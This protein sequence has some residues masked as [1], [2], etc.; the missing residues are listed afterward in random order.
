M[1]TKFASS[2]S[3]DGKKFFIEVTGI[4]HGSE[5]DFEF[6]DL[7]DMSQQAALEAKK[8]ID[9]E[10]DESTVY[11]WDWCDESA[12]RNVWLK[13]EAEGDPI[14]LP[15]FQ[16]VAD[17]PR[18]KD[19][20]DYLVHAVLP[21]TLLPTYQSSLT[22]KE[23]I[24][25][26]RAGFIYIFYNH[27][28]W[29]EIQISP[30][31]SGDYS[32]KDVNLYQYRTGRDKPFKDEARIATG[33]A[34]KEIW[35]PAKENNKGARIH[36]AFSEVQWSA[37]YLNYLEAN[38]NELV[39]RAVA[40]HQLNVDSNVDVLKASLLPPMRIRAPE[41]ELFLAEP[42]NLNRDLSGEWVT[43]TYQTI[44]E[45]ILSANDDGDKAVQVFKYAQPHRYEYA[46]KQAALIEIINSDPNQAKLWTIGDSTDFLEDAKKR[47]LRAIVLDDPLF[48]LRHH[49]FLTQSAVGYLQQ[50]YIDMSQQKYY[51][52]AE[53]VQKLVVPAKFGQQENPYYQYRNAIDNYYGGVFHR[54]LRTTERQFCC[55]DVKVLQEKLQLQVN[56]K[57]LAHVLRDISS[58]ND[59]NA[60]A[61]HVIV[62]YALSALSVNIDKLDQM[63]NP[64][65][66]VRSPYLET[67]RQILSPKDNHPLH[68]ILFPEE[69]TINLE[70]ASYSAP[71]PFNSGSG[72]ATLESLALWSKEEMLIQDE[73]LQVMDLAFMSPSNSNQEKAF[74][75][76]RRIASIMNDILKGYFDTLLNLSQDLISEAKVIQFNAAY[77]PVLGLM[78][79]TNSKMWGDI[80][81]IP[82]SGAELKGTV[83]GV[84]GHGLSYGLSA[85]D[86]EFVDSKKKSAFGRL[87]DRSGKLVASTNKNAFSSSDLIS[88]SRGSVGAKSPLKVVVVSQESQMAAAFNQA[89]TQRALHDMNRTDLNV[90][91]AYEKFRIPYFIAVVELINLKQSQHHFEKALQRTDTLYSSANALSAAADLTIALIHA[92]NLYTQNASRL[93]TASGKAA[94][95]M[96]DF[97]VKKMTF[98]N[99]KVRLVP[100]ISRLGLASIGAGFLTA[101]IAGWDA[102]RRW[103]EN[104]LDASVA[105]G[106]VAIGTLTTTVATGFFTTSAPVL[107][108]MGPV[109]WLGI[110]L[111]VAGFALY[112]FWEDTPME[113]WLKNGPFGQSPSATY[114]HLQDP[115]TAFE[116]FIGL[117]FT[118][119][120]NAYRL[121]AQTEFPE[122]FTQQMQALGATHVIHV[123]TNLAALLNSQSVRVEFYA[124]QAIEKKTITS[125]RTGSRESSELINLSSHNVTVIHQE[126]R[127]EGTAYFVKYDLIVPEYS[128]DFSLL[129]MRSYQYRYQ[130][131][132]VLR[133]KLHVE[134]ASF[135]TLA[136]EERDDSRIVNMVPTFRLDNNSDQDWAQNTVLA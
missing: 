115:T 61:A 42:S 132:F 22:Y 135:P 77:A 65:S 73:Q 20:Q 97:L 23:R 78:K 5:Q 111:A 47:H 1:S 109:A 59:I 108:G 89:N 33:V 4:Q 101:G 129:M 35:I 87:Y 72:F 46:I 53:L 9:P 103:Q 52:T 27:K 119:S 118:L 64:E 8:S 79:A 91:N 98:R 80:T 134:Q 123:N 107:F 86:R 11:S 84:H 2:P 68:R 43:R 25:P 112:M 34:L 38:Q 15:L 18:K 126:Q 104:D 14:K 48:D 56:Q 17:I 39:Q 94:V 49:A 136:L 30:E 128:T 6:Y 13:I 96:P 29:R 50:V 90:S 133:T 116:R 58:M 54:T 28:V 83:V 110:G 31:D 93:A 41:L 3:C 26:V 74:N 19:E 45:E 88:E 24:A 85:S 63:S 100:H 70:Q 55:Q 125:S 67:A 40:F 69:G 117:I 12:N 32:L 44:K 121:G 62:G 71:L 60:S 81:Y 99:G 76:E 114:A 75:L 66:D 127:N 105:M 131:V 37:Q 10:L 113:A 16:N 130:P 36:L 124:R 95:V 122:V 21:L 102:M 92:S 120:V 51:R 57:R 106:M 7:T 82:V